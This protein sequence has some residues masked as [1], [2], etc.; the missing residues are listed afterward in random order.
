LLIYNL[1][2]IIF[3]HELEALCVAMMLR[4][5]MREQQARITA[6]MLVT[7]D[8]WGVHTHGVKQLR[9]LLWERRAKALQV[10]SQT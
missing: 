6:E 1:N 2:G 8:S 3:T 10:S 4:P 7:T 9:G 5:G